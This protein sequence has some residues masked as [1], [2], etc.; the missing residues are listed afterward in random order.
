[1]IHA[2]IAMPR[3]GSCKTTYVVRAALS[4]STGTDTLA[5]FPG[6]KCRNPEPEVVT[7]DS[8]E[9]VMYSLDKL[10]PQRPRKTVTT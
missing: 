5:F 7:D 9:P 8:G 1:M 10:A 3:C 2:V 6:C 4:F